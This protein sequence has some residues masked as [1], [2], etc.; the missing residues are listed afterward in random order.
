MAWRD[1]SYAHNDDDDPDDD[2]EFPDESDMDETDEPALI[3]CPYCRREISE[4][5]EQCPH[6]RSYISVEDAP[7][8]KPFWFIVAAVV[9]VLIV[10]FWAMRGL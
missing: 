9:A 10:L 5:A 1:R 4:E 8:G 3:A 2:P 6:C 7:S